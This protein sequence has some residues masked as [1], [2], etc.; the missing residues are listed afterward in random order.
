[1]LNVDVLGVSLSGVKLAVTVAVSVAPSVAGEAGAEETEN[2]VSAG[3]PNVTVAG[4]L[5]VFF[6]FSTTSASLTPSFAVPKSAAVVAS[7]NARVA[8][9]GVTDTGTSTFGF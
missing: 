2:C 1:M 5:P 8:P 9:A 6:T 7:S 4:L 3:A